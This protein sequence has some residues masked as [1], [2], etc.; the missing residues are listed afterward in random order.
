M[1]VDVTQEAQVLQKADPAAGF[2]YGF[3]D[4]F[5]GAAERGV[6]GLGA[7]R[8]GAAEHEVDHGVDAPGDVVLDDDFLAGPGA[9]VGGERGGERGAAAGDAGGQAALLGEAAGAGERAPA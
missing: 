7:E 5:D 2:P 1:A 6:A 3:E 8:D 9:V 4:A